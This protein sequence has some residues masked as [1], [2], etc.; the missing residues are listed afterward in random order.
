MFEAPLEDEETVEAANGGDRPRHRTRRL[1]ARHL[2]P[3]EGLERLAIEVFRPALG[4]GGKRGEGGQVAAV[5]LERMRR[6]ASFDAEM[7]QVGRDQA[8]NYDSMRGFF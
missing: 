8:H 4:G 1:P 3:H 7:I 2:L 5:T 6:Q